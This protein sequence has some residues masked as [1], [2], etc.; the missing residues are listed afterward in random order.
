MRLNPRSRCFKVVRILLLVLILDS[1]AFAAVTSPESFLGFKPGADRQLA[2]WNQIVAYYQKLAAETPR[3]R[4]TELGRTT[5]GKPFLQV[6]ISSE[7]NLANLPHFKQIQARLADPRRLSEAQADALVK[8]GKFVLGISCSI[9]STEIAASQMSMQLAYKLVTEKFPHAREILDN[10]IIVMFPSSNPDGIQI[11]TDWYRQQLGTPFEGTSPPYL[12]HKYTGHDNNRDFFKLT[13]VETQMINQALW[14]EWYPAVYWDVHQ[15][16]SNG[17]RLFVPPYSDPYNPNIDPIVVRELFTLGGYMTGE[18]ALRGKQGVMTMDRYDAW[19]I[20]GNRIT[21]WY[22]NSIGILTE[23]ASARIATPI[24][25]SSERLSGREPAGS[26]GSE[27]FRDARD[28]LAPTF[29][30]PNPWPG[31]TW[32]LQDIVNY[33]L[34]AAQGLLRAVAVEK[35]YFLKNFYQIGRNTIERGEAGHPYAFVI[36]RQQQDPTTTVKLINLLVQQGVEIF[37]ATNNFGVDGKSFQAGS[38]VI[39]LNQPYGRL[40]KTLLETQ[41]YP[42]RRVVPNGPPERPYDVTGWT[43]PLLMGVQAESVD[44]PFRVSLSQVTQETPPQGEVVWAR[45]KGSGKFGYLFDHTSNTS[46]LAMNRLQKLGYKISWLKKEFRLGGHIFAPGSIVVLPP[47][48][49]RMKQFDVDIQKLAQENFLRIYPIQKKETLETLALTTPRVG[50]YRSWLPSMDEGWTRFL[51]DLYELPYQTI[52]DLDVRQGNLNARFDTIVLPQQSVRAIV[53]GNAAKSFPDRYVGGIGETGVAQLKAFVS[54]GGTLVALDTASDFVIEKLGAPV[55]NV[56]RGLKTTEFYCPGSLLGAEANLSHPIA[57]GMPRNFSAF[58]D[59]S[60]VFETKEG[61]VVANYRKEQPLE[62]GWLIGPQYVAGKSAIVDLNSG[63]GKL[64]LL[65]F[66]T[67]FR[68]WTDGTFKLL[69][70]AIF[71][72][73]ATSVTH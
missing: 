1:V 12:Y 59:S 61:R 9:H 66:R 56:V 41:Q 46:I 14:R 6:V 10:V 72:G 19:W 47:E 39:P 35:E 32:R 37:V 16:G 15:M 7:S 18:L 44:Q 42:D 62:S 49:K 27:T 17:A 54:N 63:K 26:G 52:T 29:N 65:G 31:G 67:Q 36:P 60:P 73:S 21:P 13:Q 5:L 20:G 57:Y 33:E 68:A 25:I 11:V 8:E 64:I 53:E 40:V 3:V 51:F 22:H 2:D 45:R 69:F 48:G 71:Y 70:N 43:L 55:Q 28:F 58:F 38:Y 30:F 4:V 24:Q 50:L 23:A 34:D